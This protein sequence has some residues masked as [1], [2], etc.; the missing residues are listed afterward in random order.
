MRYLLTSLFC[1]FTLSLTAQE[2]ITYPY[3]PD[4]DND[5]FVGITDLLELLGIY[6]TTFETGEIMVNDMTFEVYLNELYMLLEA[7]ALPDGTADGQ[8]LK[9]NGS[10]WVLVIP[11]AG[12]TDL[13]SCSYDST[14][15]VH[16]QSLCIYDDTC[17]V[18][19]GPGDI[20]ECGCADIPEGNCDCDG[21][22]VD[23]LNVCGG[24][25]SE[26]LDEDGICDD[27]DSCIGEAD[28]CGVC[29]GPGAI[30]DCGCSGIPEGE[31]DCEGTPDIDLDGVCDS[32]DDCVGT[33][34]AAGVCNGNCTTDEDQDGI[35]DDNGNDTCDGNVD[36]CGVCNGPGPIYECGCA[37]LTEGACD[38]AG[39]TPDEEGNCQDCLSDTD[40]DGL[41]D[42]F[43]GPCLGETSIT[44]N[45]EVYGLLEIGGKCWF[46]EN[47]RTTS[48]HSGTAIPNTPDAGDWF[49]LGH[50]GGYCAYN[51]N[52]ENTGTYGLL[53]NGYTTVAPE[54][55][56][57]QYY[58]VPTVEEWDALIEN[59][60]GATIAGGALKESG[61]DHWNAP[62]AGATNSSGFTAL[63]G[64][65]R[66]GAGFTNQ[67]EVATFWTQGGYSSFIDEVSNEIAVKS[68]FFS[69]EYVSY[70]SHDKSAG[71]SIR[72][73]RTDGLLGCT[74]QNFMEYNPLANVDDGSCSLPAVLGCLD[75]LFIEFDPLANVDD[76]TCNTLVGCSDTDFVVYNGDTYPLVAI[77]YQCWFQE[78]LQTEHY[79]NGDIIVNV[80]NGDQWSALGQSQTGAWA[81]YG[82]DTINENIYGKLYNLHAVNDSRALCPSG[83]HVPAPYAWTKL[84]DFLGGEDFAGSSMSAASG[85]GEQNGSNSS[86]FS[87]LPGGMREP[88]GYFYDINYR[89]SFGV[90]TLAN[91]TDST[92]GDSMDDE[93]LFWNWLDSGY[94]NLY[95]VEVS[96]GQWVNLDNYGNVYEEDF[97]YNQNVGVSVRCLQDYID[98]CGVTN[99]D[100]S[101]CDIDECGV[102]NGDN[103]STSCF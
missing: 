39:N 89:S 91:P 50:S 29:N 3:N 58:A 7:A 79:N 54:G 98:R 94:G 60:G 96:D 71:H 70:Y 6:G 2:T 62:N 24:E 10:E 97:F 101:S 78:N 95:I 82:N 13:E 25:C 68:M 37:D 19:D 100:G 14:A 73:I 47:L 45:G 102:I 16:L 23:A 36:E 12:C 74:N 4:S 9:W 56:C 30:Y 34:D 87:A 53:Y 5:A 72:C 93:E 84:I 86:G 92:D 17:G 88:D 63:P 44:Y 66:E 69:G 28:E 18:C 11:V 40:G 85:W 51:N 8:F 43:C 52:P 27:G 48:Y 21:N 49:A 35:C 57:P 75:D 46:K 64:G 77:G 15:H 41:Y 42:E 80:Q 1:V 103:S 61:L 31:C 81:H 59:V 90:N 26:D 38:C 32:E 20:F 55:V 83:W 67:G 22:Q 76:G 65:E 99:G 33:P